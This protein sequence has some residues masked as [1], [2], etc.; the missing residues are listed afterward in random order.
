MAKKSGLVAY[1]RRKKRK[2][3]KPSANPPIAQD[4]TEDIIPAFVAYAGTRFLSNI[5]YGIAS[6]RF[7]KGGKHIAVLSSGLAFAGVWTLIHRFESTMKYHSPAVVGSAIAAIQ[8]GAQAYFPKYGWMMG[9][10]SQNDVRTSSLPAT[11]VELDAGNAGA[12]SSPA[13]D[14]SESLLPAGDYGILS[15]G[16]LSISDAELDDLM[17]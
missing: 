11:P 9:D 16:H 12:I 17:A 8:T 13:V 7:P 2:I 1:R 5:V 14:E 3:S 15:G 6:K 10:L 4:F